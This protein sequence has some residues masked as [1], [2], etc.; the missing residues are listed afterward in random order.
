MAQND[1][2]QVT[3]VTE[4]RQKECLNIWHY[5]QNQALPDSDGPQSN[6]EATTAFA[7]A[8]GFRD[9]LV[10]PIKA[11]CGGDTSFRRIMVS[12]LF[13]ANDRA[14]LEL[15]GTGTIAGAAEDVMPRFVAITSTLISSGGAVKNGRKSFGGITELSLSDGLLTNAAA[16]TAFNNLMPLLASPLDASYA[17]LFNDTEDAFDPVIVKRLKIN[18]T[19][20]LP[21]SQVEAVTAQVI[22]AVYS[23]VASSMLSRK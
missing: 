9:D 11:T 14:A 22:A 3:L 18:N 21:A 17:G 19:Y 5:K 2:Y 4:I 8:R 20:R 12:N 15:T 23:V 7:L 10:D 16:L 1:L 13:D 6:P